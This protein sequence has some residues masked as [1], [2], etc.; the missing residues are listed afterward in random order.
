M[1]AES[2]NEIPEYPGWREYSY[3]S[4]HTTLNNPY[5]YYGQYYNQPYP[6]NEPLYYPCAPYEPFP[7]DNED[8]GIF[9]KKKDVDTGY[10]SYKPS[11]DYKPSYPQKSSYEHD[12]SYGHQTSYGHKTDYEK[13]KYG[14]QP[15]YMYKP[16]TN[17]KPNYEHKTLFDIKPKLIHDSHGHHGFHGLLGSAGETED[18]A[19][20]TNEDCDEQNESF[21]TSQKNGAQHL[22]TD[23]QQ[24]IILSTPPSN[25]QTINQFQSSREINGP[26]TQ[27]HRQNQLVQSKI[28]FNLSPEIQQNNRNSGS[29]NGPPA[30][31]SM[32][33]NHVLQSRPLGP[34][35]Q[36]N[37]IGASSQEANSNQVNEKSAFIGSLRHTQMQNIQEQKSGF[38][39]PPGPMQ[40]YQSYQVQST[41]M[42][43]QEAQF[44]QNQINSGLSASSAPQL[45]YNNI[46][47]KSSRLNDQQQAEGIQ[48]HTGFPLKN[49]MQNL[50]VQATN[51]LN[52]PSAQQFQ[53]QTTTT[54]KGPSSA[55]TKKNCTLTTY[56]YNSQEKVQSQNVQQCRDDFNTQTSSGVR[57]F[58]FKF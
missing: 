42:N 38:N 57:I 45:S 56:N 28:G 34:M 58:Y 9:F 8:V 47:M 18:K 3:G 13:P 7:E 43:S 25:Q 14:Y 22:Q 44:N 35:Q 2:Y 21:N 15:N 10:N 11:Y 33:I 41:G 19:T 36:N 49:Q 20:Q 4:Q 51:T 53:S 31:Q 46:Q 30:P 5:G 24:N 26:P 55:G 12:S 32:K 6:N 50:H 54:F 39:C 1:Q 37:Q 17:Y 40:Q 16:S 27:T 29:A 23:K 52:A 48:I